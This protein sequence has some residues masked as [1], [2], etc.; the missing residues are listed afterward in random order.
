M[1]T[2]Y[3]ERND[4]EYFPGKFFQIRLAGK[5]SRVKTAAL[6][7]ELGKGKRI[8]WMILYSLFSIN[9]R[10]CSW[11]EPFLDRKLKR[12]RCPLS[13]TPSRSPPPPG[14]AG[15]SKLWVSF[16]IAHISEDSRGI[17][18]KSSLPVPWKRV[19][20][21]LFWGLVRTMTFHGLKMRFYSD[22]HL[23]K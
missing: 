13:T 19:L 17:F 14:P 10:L 7:A 23:K 16:L 6:R 1:F 15:K 9:Y 20:H 12:I 21:F 4:L 22:Q 18:L 3:N 2:R 8:V 11:K 5:G